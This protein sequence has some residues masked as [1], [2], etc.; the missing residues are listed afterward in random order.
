MNSELNID[1]LLKIA[2][3]SIIKKSE[4]YSKLSETEKTIC[5]A[6]F[7]AGSKWAFDYSI[8]NLTK[9]ELDAND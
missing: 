2:E 1:S 4:E 8:K 9:N 6:S 7:R 3:D 5:L